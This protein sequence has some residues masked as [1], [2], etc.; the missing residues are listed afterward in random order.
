VFTDLAKYTAEQRNYY[1]QHERGLQSNPGIN[2]AIGIEPYP[3]KRDPI[4]DHALDDSG[5]N[6]GRLA[7][8]GIMEEFVKNTMTTEVRGIAV[9]QWLKFFTKHKKP[10]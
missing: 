5:K 2:L 7:R 9:N 8:Y 1:W 6:F 4:S 10:D 3:T